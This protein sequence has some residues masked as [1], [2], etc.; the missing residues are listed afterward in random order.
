MTQPTCLANRP[1]HSPVRWRGQSR[2]GGFN[3][4]SSRACCRSARDSSSRHRLEARRLQGVIVPQLSRDRDGFGG[5][6][7]A[8]D[9]DTGESLTMTFWNNAEALEASTEAANRMRDEARRSDGR[10]HRRRGH[11][12]GVPQRNALVRQR[13]SPA[14][15]RL[16]TASLGLAVAKRLMG[17]CSTRAAPS[18]WRGCLSFH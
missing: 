13:H 17:P 6:M 7:I 3:A 12:S 9:P 15:A 18:R 14:R 16:T 10:Q 11:V 4:R 5:L 1:P 2:R 8:A